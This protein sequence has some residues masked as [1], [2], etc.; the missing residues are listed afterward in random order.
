MPV[1]SAI[2]PQRAGAVTAHGAGFL[3]QCCNLPRAAAGEAL[4]FWP[5]VQGITQQ[6]PTCPFTFSSAISDFQHLCPAL[7][8]KQ[9]QL[10]QCKTC[11]PEFTAWGD[12]SHHSVLT[13]GLSSTLCWEHSCTV[14]ASVQEFATKPKQDVTQSSVSA[15]AGIIWHS[16]SHPAPVSTGETK[17]IECPG[18]CRGFSLAGL[19]CTV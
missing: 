4:H 12:T 16:S 8:N 9:S 15:A 2:T 3:P 1:T 18:V 10:F 6:C 19:L 11:C 7:I 17:G 13:R 5:Y 14:G